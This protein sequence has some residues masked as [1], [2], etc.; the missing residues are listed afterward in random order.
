[1][2]K[3]IHDITH[4]NNHN[5]ESKDECYRYNAYQELQT[6]KREGLVTLFI[7]KDKI[8]KCRFFSKDD[9]K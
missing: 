7:L 3:Y 5:C 1:M 4:C 2:S 6:Q 8:K 9:V